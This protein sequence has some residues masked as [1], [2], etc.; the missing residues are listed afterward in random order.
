MIK[1]YKRSEVRMGG[2]MSSSRL[3][4]NYCP[5]TKEYFLAVYDDDDRRQEIVVASYWYDEAGCCHMASSRGYSYD[6]VRELLRL[7]HLTSKTLVSYIRDGGQV[8]WDQPK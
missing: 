4:A 8:W 3:P 6:V 5:A 2:K 1:L 7:G